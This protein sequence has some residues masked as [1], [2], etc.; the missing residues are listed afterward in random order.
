MAKSKEKKAKE[1]TP[2]KPT[3][4]NV[5]DA[6]YAGDKNVAQAIPTYADEIRAGVKKAKKVVYAGEVKDAAGNELLTKAVTEIMSTNPYSETVKDMFGVLAVG[7]T[8]GY[9]KM[10]FGDSYG[11]GVKLKKE[12]LMKK[13]TDEANSK[14]EKFEAG[15]QLPKD[16]TP[17]EKEAL[18]AAKRFGVAASYA[19]VV[20]HIPG[21]SSYANL[22]EA[23]GNL[24]NAPMSIAGT[25]AT[26]MDNYAKSLRESRDVA[27]KKKA[28]IPVGEK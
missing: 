9:D 13:V 10:T 5:I 17:E 27:A 4:S 2:K 8:F 1:E 26:M 3:L 28:G 6:L 18:K 24:R 15:L 11:E 22:T 12:A 20:K 25:G 7:E 21:K 14:I 16:V 19:E 23:Y